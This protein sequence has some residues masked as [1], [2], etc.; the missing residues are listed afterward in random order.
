MF[1]SR[2]Y[3]IPRYRVNDGNGTIYCVNFFHLS[4]DRG[5]SL[6][7]VHENR[8]NHSYSDT[9]F[10]GRSQPN[11]NYS[12]FVTEHKQVNRNYTNDKVRSGDADRKVATNVYSDGNLIIYY[13]AVVTLNRDKVRS[14]TP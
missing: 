7:K 5:P 3:S 8:D 11:Q 2:N 13:S 12:I 4:T 1:F 14:C 9:N 10:V 6:Q